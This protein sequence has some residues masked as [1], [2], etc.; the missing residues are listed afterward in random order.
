[1]CLGAIR[2]KGTYLQFGNKWQ[3]SRSDQAHPNS[4][5]ANPVAASRANQISENRKYK[6]L[7][8]MAFN[9]HSP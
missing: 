8:S 3:C 7:R 2:I 4:K 1:V 6:V 5:S 9:K